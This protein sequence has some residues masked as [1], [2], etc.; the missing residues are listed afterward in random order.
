MT[1]T[2][3]QRLLR[4]LMTNYEKAVRPV[5]KASDPITLKIGLTLN[6]IDVVSRYRLLSNNDHA[7]IAS[8]WL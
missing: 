6:Q 1:D 4:S 2:D 8:I 5:L 7:S 3:E